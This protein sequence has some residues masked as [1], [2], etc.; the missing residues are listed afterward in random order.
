VFES[1]WETT[2][3][4]MR[5]AVDEG[6]IITRRPPEVPVETLDEVEGRFVYGRERC[7]RCDT[8]LEHLEIAGR[9]I[10]ACPHCQ[11]GD[12]GRTRPSVA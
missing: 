9:A 12:L 7:G 6:R 4:V 3:R 10:N 1:L 8:E 2:V 5:R 11:P